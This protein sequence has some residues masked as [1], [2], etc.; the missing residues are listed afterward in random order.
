MIFIHYLEPFPSYASSL[1]VAAAITL[2]GMIAGLFVYRRFRFEADLA[3]HWWRIK[4]ENVIIERTGVRS[5]TS[6]GSSESSSTK[7]PDR[8]E[9]AQKNMGDRALQER[10][11][12]TYKGMHV[13]VTFLDVK[14]L[15]VTRNIL[16]QLKQVRDI[17]HENLVRFI[18]LCPE[19]PNV[20][21]LTEHCSRG[22]LRDLL[23][24]DSM[25]IDWPF[26]FSIISDIV[27]GLLFIHQS[28]ILY[29]GRLRSKNCLI[30]TRF[31]VKLTEFGLRSLWNQQR[32]AFIN[33][34]I[35]H[36]V[37]IGSVPPFRP[38]VLP[39][40][41]PTDLMDILHQCWA[42][43]P[44]S[45]P[46]V[47]QVKH[48]LKRI[49]KG[50]GSKNFL[51]NLLS[52]M[53]Q[54]ANNLESLVEEKTA[55][56]L[57]EKKKS[58]ELLYQVLPRLATIKFTVLFPAVDTAVSSIGFSEGSKSNKQFKRCVLFIIL[59]LKRRNKYV[60]EQ[61]KSGNHVRPETFE[62]VTIYFSDI[63]GFTS[64]SAESTPMEVVNF[65]ND[66]YTCF[67]A[68]I[69]NYDVYK[70]ETIGDAYMVVSGLPIRN[71]NEH[72]NEIARMSLS[73]LHAIDRFEIRHRPYKK[74]QLRIGI[75]SGPCAAGVVGLKMPRYCLFG[76]TV[77][78]ASR[79]ESNGAAMKVHVS[80]HTK[81]MLDE[82]GTFILSLRG[83]TEIKGKGIIR[84]YWLEGE[85]DMPNY[86]ILS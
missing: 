18:G 27:E 31:V 70:V 32:Q 45:R 8:E 51:D 82:F 43:G 61:L 58:E 81:T 85:R 60:A 56:F 42:E 24:N 16:L 77:N 9:G 46:S 2:M 5:A 68:I 35:L 13:S 52:R 11:V 74:V 67:D 62:C 69:E 71:G 57:E 21:L 73:L 47:Y 15:I 26:R 4:W 20:S 40:N 76:D 79:M 36:R 53:E 83:D 3:S 30:D 80:H 6:I 1:I 10:C 66:L 23:S 75:H 84:T 86:Q 34:K 54:Y 29:H 7:P 65:L 28:G 25:K 78:T 19:E 72:V 50:M 44:S 64:L 14:R 38:E 22:T 33:P 49:T 39:E 63:V 12:G 59:K 41:C 17:T 55:A 48:Q 37:K